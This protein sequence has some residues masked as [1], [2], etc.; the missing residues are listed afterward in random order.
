MANIRGNSRPRAILPGKTK[1][2]LAHD[3]RFGALVRGL[4]TAAAVLGQL[5]GCLPI[6]CWTATDLFRAPSKGGSL[7]KLRILEDHLLGKGGFLCTSMLVGWDKEDKQ[8]MGYDTMRNQ[9]TGKATKPKHE[10]NSQR[11]HRS[12]P[13]GVQ[14]EPSCPY[15]DAKEDT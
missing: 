11:C 9:T 7:H 13:K 2:G 5:W 8:I 3:R 1:P 4:S 6:V 12:R 14:P 10:F 15:F